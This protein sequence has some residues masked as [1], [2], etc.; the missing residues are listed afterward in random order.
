MSTDDTEERREMV[1]GLTCH[2]KEDL[3]EDD[4]GFYWTCDKNG[5]EC[6]IDGQCPA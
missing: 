4:Q 1:K 5:K 2:H 6:L 3:E